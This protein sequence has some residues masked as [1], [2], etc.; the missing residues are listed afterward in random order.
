VGRLDYPPVIFDQYHL[1]KANQDLIDQNAPFKPN[2]HFY[3]ACD[4]WGTVTGINNDGKISQLLNIRGKRVIR[5]TGMLYRQWIEAEL[6]SPFRQRFDPNYI[7]VTS[8]LATIQA[9]LIHPDRRTEEFSHAGPS[10]ISTFPSTDLSGIG[11][12]DMSSLLL[13]TSKN[14]KL[15]MTPTEYQA[16]REQYKTKSGSYETIHGKND[17]SVWEYFPEY[18]LARCPLCGAIYTDRMDT[19][20]LQHWLLGV[21]DVVYSTEKRW[22][23]YKECAG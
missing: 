4:Y 14:L 21:T 8:D 9:E 2:C 13:R 1:N 10:K 7:E 6:Q 22:L 16:L 15:L 12:V 3:I 20:S 5:E 11:K 19:Y 17:P 18:L 23:I